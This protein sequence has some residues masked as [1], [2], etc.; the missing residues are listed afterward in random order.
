MKKNFGI[1]LAVC[2]VVFGLSFTASAEEGVTDTTIRI[3]QWVLRRCPAAPWGAVA[4]E[5]ESFSDDQ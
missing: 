4:A 5:Q 3:G 1:W 2:F